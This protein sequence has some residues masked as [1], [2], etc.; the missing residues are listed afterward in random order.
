MI[1]LFVSCN[2]LLRGS[3]ARPPVVQAVREARSSAVL[4]SMQGLAL[5]RLT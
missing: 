4:S 2:E 3:A 5:V 1:Y